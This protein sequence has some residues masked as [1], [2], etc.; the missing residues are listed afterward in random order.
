MLDIIPFAFRNKLVRVIVRDGGLWWCAP[1][2]CAVLEIKNSRDAV[3]RLPAKDVAT[4][5]LGELNGANTL[6]AVNGSGPNTV[7]SAD[8]VSPKGDARTVNI[9][10]EA[11][12]YKLIFASRKP[13]ALEFQDFV[14]SVIL[15]QIRRTGAYADRERIQAAPEGPKAAELSPEAKLAAV[16]ETRRLFGYAKARELWAVLGLPRVPQADEATL[17][18]AGYEALDTILEAEI[19]GLDSSWVEVTISVGAQTDDATY[20]LIPRVSIVSES[21]ASLFERDIR[22]GPRAR[23]SRDDSKIAEIRLPRYI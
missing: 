14:T 8:G 2:L 15:P 7:G 12:L 16:R 21:R 3:A 17:E 5:T 11:G 13:E 18:T 4:I 23:G 22:L 20:S 9:V 10:S 6:H 19:G 1:D